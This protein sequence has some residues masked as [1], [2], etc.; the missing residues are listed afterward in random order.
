MYT[1]ADK[2]HVQAG[3]MPHL[4]EGLQD[5]VP[6]GIPNSAM[7]SMLEGTQGGGLPDLEQRMRERLALDNQIPDA[8]REAARLASSVSGARTPEEV[9]TQLGEKMGADFS[10]VRFHT[11]AGAVGMADNIG[12]RAYTSGQDVYFGQGGFDPA[13]AAHELVH[14]AQQGVVESAVPTVSAP[15]GG[16]QMM[17]K[18]FQRVGGFFKNLF[19]SKDKKNME[20]IAGTNVASRAGE[21]QPHQPFTAAQITNMQSSSSGVRSDASIEERIRPITGAMG[22]EM[23]DY[24]DALEQ[25]GFDFERAHKGTQEFIPSQN[26]GA[27]VRYNTSSVAATKKLLSMFSSHLDT[28][29]MQDMLGEVY[30]NEMQ[31]PGKTQGIEGYS[32][33]EGRFLKNILSKG[34]MPM[35]SLIRKTNASGNQ[36][37]VP[38]LQDMQ[39]TTAYL[40]TMWGNDHLPEELQGLMDAYA[41][42]RE[43]LLAGG[44]GGLMYDPAAKETLRRQYAA[45]SVQPDFNPTTASGDEML[46]HTLRQ[47]NGAVDSGNDIQRDFFRRN[48]PRH[49]Q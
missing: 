40:E 31:N 20:I 27:R 43:K 19:K 25:S 9:K 32:A 5:A 7:L 21:Q 47:F 41:P 33:M 42:I 16:V 1:N 12:A 26:S 36:K 46:A 24:F 22:N 23:S 38:F 8:E 18:L 14:T 6:S 15:T 37:K 29:E 13:V 2:K 10:N 35:G 49:L 39:G 34:L 44:R 45:A 48:L 30:K 28:Q 3:S 11:D 17:P 4:P